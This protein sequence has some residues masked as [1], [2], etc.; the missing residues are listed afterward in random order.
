MGRIKREVLSVVMVMAIVVSLTFKMDVMAADDSGVAE[1]KVPGCNATFTLRNAGA[2]YWENTSR[3]GMHYYSFFF[4]NG[5]ADFTCDSPAI[6]MYQF[7]DT[8]LLCY[9][10][11]SG[12]WDS[13][14]L[15][16]EEKWFCEVFVNS[17]G[18]LATTEKQADESTLHIEFHYNMSESEMN[19]SSGK[20]PASQLHPVSDLKVAAV[21]KDNNAETLKSYKGNNTE[22]DAYYY[23]IN[24]ADL[25]NAIGVNGDA[26]LKHWND[27]GK[28]EG[29]KAK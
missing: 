22:F 21:S 4:P 9:S 28:K 29:R 8:G 18:T 5:A 27:F 7:A 1:V 20:I 12:S 6:V 26:L 23:Y 25:Q 14:K 3:I 2:N 15:G 24:N 17:D 10:T 11:F 19:T 13:S 16:S